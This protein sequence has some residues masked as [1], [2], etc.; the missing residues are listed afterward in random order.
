MHIHP[1]LCP[2]QMLSLMYLIFSK[3]ERIKFFDPTGFWVWAKQLF[4]LIEILFCKSLG[5][6]SQAWVTELVFAAS[7][8]TRGFFFAWRIFIKVVFRPV[9][10]LA[11]K[12]FFICSQETMLS[13]CISIITVLSRIFN[14]NSMLQLPWASANHG[15][16]LNQNPLCPYS[17]RIFSPLEQYCTWPQIFPA[18]HGFERSYGHSSSSMVLG[19]RLLSADRFN[20]YISHNFPLKHFSHRN[21][22]YIAKW[23]HWYCWCLKK[24]NSG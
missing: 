23:L 1:L 15:S 9:F 4:T 7:A 3:K 8:F 2:V 18:L 11:N 13:V 21:S 24:I 10:S 6:I 16:P 20:K 22:T 12:M 5:P 17:P 19:P 14:S